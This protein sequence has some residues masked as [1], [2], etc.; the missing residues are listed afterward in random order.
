M[1]F[2][3]F[4]ASVDQYDPVVL[5]FLAKIIDFVP[6]VHISLQLLQFHI[7]YLDAPECKINVQS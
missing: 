2:V 4:F 6:L 5:I 7:I 3:L 1:L